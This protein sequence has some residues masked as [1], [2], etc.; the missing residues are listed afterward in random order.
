MATLASEDTERVKRDIE[1]HIEEQLYDAVG[2]LYRRLA[3]A[4][5][6]VSE[7]LTEDDNGKPWCSGT[8]W[9]PT[10]GTS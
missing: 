1:L 10:S 6:R 7:R 5:E 8:P 2:D 4:V 9:S 3:E